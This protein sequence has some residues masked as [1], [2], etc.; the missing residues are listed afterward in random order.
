LYIG[1][2]TVNGTATAG[3]DYTAKASVVMMTPSESTKTVTIQTTATGAGPNTAFS[4]QIE[5]PF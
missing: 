5:E 3:V 1:Y 2:S 4:L